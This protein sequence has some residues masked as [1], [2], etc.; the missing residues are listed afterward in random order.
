MPVCV[1]ASFPLEFLLGDEYAAAALHRWLVW[2]RDSESILS[3]PLFRAEV[4]SAIRKRVA[5]GGLAADQGLNALRRA[6]AWPVRV[7]PEDRQWARLQ[8]RAYELAARFRKRH[9]YDAQY[10]AAAEFAGTELW[11]ADER[12]FNTVR[13]DLPWVRWI[14]DYGA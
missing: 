12:L 3:P 10:L 13:N 6:L 4:T 8:L 11:T 5:G 2:L 14:G 1:D 9:A 7:W